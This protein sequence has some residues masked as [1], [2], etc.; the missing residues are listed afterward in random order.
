MCQFYSPIVNKKLQ[1]LD[2]V[3][4]N[5]NHETVVDKFKL[6]DD[7]LQDRDF[8]RLEII[9]EDRDIFNHKISNWVYKVDEI[10]TLPKWYIKN[11]IKI[12]KEVYSKLK[13]IFKEQFLIGGEYK[14]IDKN[15][16]FVKDVKIGILKSKVGKMCGSSQVG[17][18]Y[19]SSQVSEMLDSSQVGKMCGSSQVGKMYGSSQVGKMWD[20]SQV[21]EMYSSSQVGKM[22]GSSQ[23]G[24]MYCSSQVGK[25]Y[26]SSQVGKMCGSSQ[27]GK[28]YSSSQVGKMWCSSQVGK[29]YNSSQ[30]G[31][32]YD[33]SQVGKM[34]D[35]SQV[36]KMWNS[37]QVGKMLDSNTINVWSKNV[38]IKEQLNGKSVIIKRYLKN[39]KV[40]IK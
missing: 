7:K 9:P 8:V 25:M 14:T 34:Y 18:M 36:G 40:I 22:Y 32:M 37:S 1:I 23:V 11:E 15:I 35:S 16:R 6:A 29:M 20:S 21:G 10:N 12:K 2:C 28:M 33:S 19:G 27:V 3:E 38:K 17:K 26:S 24:A 4:D 13:K 5:D 31:K 30:V 39:V